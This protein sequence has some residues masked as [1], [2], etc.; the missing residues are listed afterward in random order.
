MNKEIRV[1]IASPYTNGWMPANVQLQIETC[2][3]LMDFGYY[4]FVPVLAHF[5][6]IYSLRTEPEWLQLGFVWLKQC[7]AVLRL[8]N[9][10]KEGN[11]ILSQGSDQE[12]ALARENNIPVFYSIEDLNDHFKINP[13]TK[14]KKYKHPAKLYV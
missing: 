6:Q 8:Q 11:Q 10:D 12:E 7:D 3:K 1:Y 4:P 5:L 9:T 2:H 14:R 13:K